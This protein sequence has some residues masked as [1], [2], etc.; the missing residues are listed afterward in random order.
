MDAATQGTESYRLCDVVMRLTVCKARLDRGHSGVWEGGRFWKR[1]VCGEYVKHLG[2]S[3]GQGWL[4]RGRVCVSVLESRRR[5]E[6]L[7][8]CVP[9]AMLLEGPCCC[10]QY[11]DLLAECA[12][13]C[14][15]AG[16]DDSARVSQSAPGRGQGLQG[17]RAGR[18]T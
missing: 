3:G 9:V 6:C 1:G 16:D 8:S 12:T 4:G 10:R 14:L 13:P 11:L 15:A 7:L 17:R 2:G 18:S 5:Q